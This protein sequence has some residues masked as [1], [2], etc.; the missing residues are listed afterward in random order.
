MFNSSSQ[1]FF[2]QPLDENETRYVGEPSPAIDAAWNDLLHA[3]YVALED[4]EA[5]QIPVEH[6]AKIWHGGDE[7]DFMELGVFHNLHCLNEIRTVLD[8]RKHEYHNPKIGRNRRDGR[9]HTIHTGRVHLD[10]CIDQ[11]RQALMCHSDLTPV[12]MMPVEG[13][14]DTFLGNGEAHTCRDF[15]AIW[16][17]VEMRGRKR[18]SLGE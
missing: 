6:R 8:Q 5:Q 12:P 9:H 11:I 7:F 3:Q 14:P 16:K 13:M 10:H 17:W 15:D 1:S 18:K 2:L 4:R